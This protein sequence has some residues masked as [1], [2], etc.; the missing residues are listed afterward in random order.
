MNVIFTKKMC[1]YVYVYF[2]H[3]TGERYDC[4]W[5][6]SGGIELEGRRVL[7]YILVNILNC[8]INHIFFCIK[9]LKN[10]IKFTFR[11]W[12]GYQIPFSRTILNITI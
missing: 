2:F 6:P 4:L 5:G 1:I 7:L 11:E 12:E 9:I 3:V 10:K 8:F